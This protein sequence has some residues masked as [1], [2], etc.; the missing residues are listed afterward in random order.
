MSLPIPDLL[1]Q[2]EILTPQIGNFLTQFE[3]FATKL[4]HQLGQISRLGGRKHVDKRVFHDGTACNPVLPS[5][6]RPI[7]PA[8]TSWA[9]PYLGNSGNPAP[10]GFSTLIRRNRRC[11]G[12]RHCASV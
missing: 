2:L 4:P 3:H 11:H 8:E 1:Q 6:K 5:V 7:V 10:L 12:Q 9:K